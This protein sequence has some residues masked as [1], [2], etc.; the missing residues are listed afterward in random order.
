MT[1][2]ATTHG[3][4]FK[5]GLECAGLNLLVVLLA[6]GGAE[7]GSWAADSDGSGIGLVVGL[8]VGMLSHSA[9]AGRIADAETRSAR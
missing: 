7:L 5:V 2:L 9:G 6:A 3:S 1:T 4:V 8:A